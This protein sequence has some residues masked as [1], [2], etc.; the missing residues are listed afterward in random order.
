MLYKNPRYFEIQDENNIQ[1]SNCFK[2]NR[3]KINNMLYNKL[4]LFFTN[5]TRRLLNV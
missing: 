1:Q 5:Y 3:V 2:R 4:E